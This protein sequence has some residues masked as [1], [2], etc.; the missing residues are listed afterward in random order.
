MVCPLFFLAL[1]G[2]SFYSHLVP[3][4]VTDY[5][6]ND[7]PVPWSR[8]L[9]VLVRSRLL[10]GKKSL[11]L[12]ADIPIPFASHAVWCWHT[13]C[14]Y[15]LT[16]NA[17][18]YGSNPANYLLYC[19]MQCRLWLLRAVTPKKRTGHALAYSLPL[20]SQFLRIFCCFF[21]LAC[22]C[23]YVVWLMVL[24]IAFCF[25]FVGMRCCRLV[26][27]ISRLFTSSRLS[28]LPCPRILHTSRCG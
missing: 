13:S 27:R 26:R 7:Y 6:W 3:R 22:V 19:N 18:V 8:L 28:L 17:S 24:D 5:Y 12:P 21:F 15:V 9:L 16:K 11:V 14:Y 23:G 2:V 4:I 10:R 25:F 1:A 20:L